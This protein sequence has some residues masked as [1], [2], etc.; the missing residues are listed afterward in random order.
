MCYITKEK[1]EDLKQK[2]EYLKT[3]K[4]QEIVQRIK[5]AKEMGDISE[6]AELD[7]ANEERGMNEVEI[8]KMEDLIRHAKIVSNENAQ[9]DWVG[10]GSTVSFLLGK[11]EVTYQV[12]GSEDADLEQ[13]KISNES[14]L[15]GALTGRK[16]GEAFEANL[17]AGKMTIKIL[18]IK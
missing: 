1:L 18:S 5:E 3:A 11:N 8:S 6:N 7:V 10:I 13:K 12:V 16:V 17:P 2:L 15:G 14:P 9:K 4:R